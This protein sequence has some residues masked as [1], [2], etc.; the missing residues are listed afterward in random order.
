MPIYSRD[1]EESRRSRARV[2]TLSTRPRVR[3]ALAR[4]GRA[5]GGR[6]GES[7]RARKDLD[8][9][10]RSG[11]SRR[12]VVLEQ[13]RIRSP[14]VTI[15]FVHSQGRPMVKTMKRRQAALL[16]AFLRKLLSLRYR[17][18]GGLQT[19]DRY[20][21]NP[22]LG[23]TRGHRRFSTRR[24]RSLANYFRNSLEENLP[25]ELSRRNTG[26]EGR[27]RRVGENGFTATI[28]QGGDAN[29]IGASIR[30]E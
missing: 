11:L 9:S 20:L 28:S 1:G 14:L 3:V 26:V 15:L 29:G 23:V 10:L 21:R 12:K 5:G 25:E 7:T 4:A 13:A 27:F 16:A 18:N 17:R 19:D 30:P 24:P 2:R 6:E 22:W 8:S